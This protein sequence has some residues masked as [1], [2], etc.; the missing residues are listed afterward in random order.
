MEYKDFRFKIILVVLFTFFSQILA[1]SSFEMGFLVVIWGITKSQSLIAMHLF[2]DVLIGVPVAA[3]LC[4]WFYRYFAPAHA[5]Y[6]SFAEGKKPDPETE[7]KATN[8]FRKSRRKFLAANVIAYGTIAAVSLAQGEYRAI[9]SP[10]IIL[11]VLIYFLLAFLSTLFEASMIAKIVEKPRKMASIHTLDEG[12]RKERGEL[13]LRTRL[14]LTNV[15][16]I[17]LI[18]TL[19]LYVSTFALSQSSLY[20]QSL[21]KVA[22]GQM[23]SDEAARDYQDRV[24]KMF[25]VDPDNVAFPSSE[26]GK[27]DA[28]MARALIGILILI[29]CMLMVVALVEWI[30]AD[31]S[32]RQVKSVT[33][34]LAEM[35]AGSGDL[36]KRIE[37]TQYDEVGRLVSELNGFMD[38]LQK[39]FRAVRQTSRVAAD[40]S[41]ELTQE[42]TITSDAGSQLADGITLIAESV[43]KN[44]AGFEETAKNLKEVFESLDNVISSVNSQAGFVTQTSA[45]V[46]Q[47]AENVKSVSEATERADEFASKLA[48][49][50]ETGTSSVSE[51]IQAIKK[52]EESSKKVTE[53]VSVIAQIAAQTNLLAMNAAIEAAHAGESGKGFAV[54]ANEVRSLAESSAKS[55]KGINVQIKKMVAAVRNGVSLSAKAGEE[56]GHIMEDT[57]STTGLVRR[58]AEA[59]NEQNRSSAGILESME[60]LVEE[61]RY[62]KNNAMEQKRRNDNVHDEVR[63]NT[64]NM[65]KI[66]AVAKE[67]SAEGQKIVKA[68]AD[69][70]KI[71]TQSM[72]LAKRL[73][74]LVEGF[75]L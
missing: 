4:A 75:N 71:E 24:G 47:M 5:A 67:Q 19:M 48:K 64:E 55:A 35:R 74:T 69:L 63:R 62:I 25:P 39:T 15:A 44:L 43:E 50:A 6:R 65:Q 36:T 26:P 22:T 34:K 1:Q 42:I 60:K 13:N 38:S 72:N 40:S 11:Q 73:S 66:A 58:I 7:M 51:S 9:L 57:E 46:S 41:I 33:G 3:L 56:L 49:A 61:T 14:I 68:I 37:I 31:E 8:C 30:I 18:M 20:A 54:V 16:L 10:L 21:G 52:V 59:M 27:I 45:A 53:M 23:T 32:V 70:R 28:A 17:T 29:A 12:T 2:K